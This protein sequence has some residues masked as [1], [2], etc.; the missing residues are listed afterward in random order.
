MSSEVLRVSKPEDEERYGRFTELRTHRSPEEQEEHL[1]RMWE[2]RPFIVKEIQQATDELIGIM[3]KYTSLDLVANLWLRNGVFDMNKYVESNSRLRPHFVEHLAMLELKDK[4][5]TLRQPVLVD[6]GDVD[7]AQQLLGTIFHKTV[8]YHM[9]E[10][11]D[12]SLAGESNS[13]KQLRFITLLRETVVGP[14]AYDFHWRAVLSGLFDWPAVS[15][16]L[17]SALGID[18]VVTMEC[19]E[20][21]H[22]LMSVAL[23]N[24]MVLARKF[25]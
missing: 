7:R 12:P 9:A 5:C 11:A 25:H 1:R 10:G 22:S 8:W 20:A 6:G 15:D 17:R 3:H 21:V 14:P 24:R 4:E 18:L 13:M 19:V 2:S 23:S 16:S